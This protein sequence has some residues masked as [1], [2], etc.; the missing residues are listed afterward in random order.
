MSFDHNTKAE[1]DLKNEPLIYA[2]DSVCTEIVVKISQ[3]LE[4]HPFYKQFESM[5]NSDKTLLFFQ[6]AL[7][8]EIFPYIVEMVNNMRELKNQITT[9]KT[10]WIPSNGIFTLLREHLPSDRIAIK[11]SLKNHLSYMIV[12]KYCLLKEFMKN[13]RVNFVNFLNKY[14]G[15]CDFEMLSNNNST[16][17]VHYGEGIDLGKRSDIVWFPKSGINA[18]R[19]LV[20]FD[21]NG[22]AVKN[23]FVCS[24]KERMTEC[25]N[26]LG[27]RW[28]FIPQGII[29]ANRKNVW[30]SEF[31]HLPK[32]F[33]DLSDNTKDATGEWIINTGK[34]L[35]RRVFFWKEFFEKFNIKI[36]FLPEE[37]DITNLAQGIAFDMIGGK[38][39]VTVGKQ[40]SDFGDP[41]KTLAR[42][43][44]KDIIFTWNNRSTDYFKPEYNKVKVQVIAGHPNDCNFSNY[45][46]EL[47]G[48]K[49]QFVQNGARFIIGLFDSGHNIGG[50]CN[51]KTIEMESLYSAVLN[52]VLE[53]KS[54]GLVIKSKKPYIIKMLPKILELLS[55]AE[56]AGRC[57]RL[58]YE[59]LPSTVSQIADMAIG[60]GVSSALTEAVIAG[61][62]G[63]HY[64]KEFPRRHE[65]YKWGYE[66]LVFTNLERMI[67][68]IKK[69]KENP[70]SNPDLGDWAPYLDSL[71]PFRDG[72]A[73]ERMGTYLR[74]CL[75]GFDA[76]LSKDEVIK[77]ANEKYAAQWG[78]DKVIPITI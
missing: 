59:Q 20:Y 45:N 25:L 11:D 24:P 67:N 76:G 37:C 73:G 77:Q 48:I 66:K 14:W 32:W 40:R 26:K 64:H 23:R 34:K 57:F 60:A 55:K 17:A 78:S 13:L 75:E 19:L 49:K 51:F 36:L 54:V 15:S 72:R 4:A 65:Y 74:W 27:M 63:V 68:A 18:E 52:W 9:K 21:T 47:Q 33:T 22:L 42:C 50:Y 16:I 46:A 71:D 44:T 30:V 7:K 38:S 41:L 8:V 61:C 39:G 58:S 53:D 28:I 62:R 35:L 70:A 12:S 29:S 43:H 1:C 56:S 69:Y 31:K 5:L 2:V 6:S 10:I 3:K